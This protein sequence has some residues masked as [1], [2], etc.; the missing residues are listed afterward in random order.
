MARREPKIALLD[1]NATVNRPA[2]AERAG[3]IAASNR[4][5]AL[6]TGYRA[7]SGP[8]SSLHKKD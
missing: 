1:K 6:S 2:A 4:Q 8:F 5:E 3:E 7:M